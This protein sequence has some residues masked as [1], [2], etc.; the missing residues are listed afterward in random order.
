MRTDST[1]LSGTALDAARSLV[2]ERYGSQFL[3]D[4]PRFY[5][6]QAKGAQEAHEAIRPA[7]EQ[8]QDMDAAARELRPDVRRGD[9]SMN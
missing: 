7:G 4:E 8:F 3:P 1:N 9:G 5:G 2:G 6:K